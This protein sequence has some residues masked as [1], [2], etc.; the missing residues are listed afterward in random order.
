M[1][2][3]RFSV[4]YIEHYVE[5]YSPRASVQVAA[6]S[7]PKW[8]DA[9]RGQGNRTAEE[10]ELRQLRKQVRDLKE[11]DNLVQGTSPFRS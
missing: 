8:H 10:E 3:I 2:T 6:R 1:Y 5:C 11:E 4:K 9:F 7:R